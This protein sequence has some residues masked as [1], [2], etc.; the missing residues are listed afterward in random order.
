MPLYPLT[1]KWVSTVSVLQ[2]AASSTKFQPG[3]GSSK[4]GLEGPSLGP[5]PEILDPEPEILAQEPP[6]LATEPQILAPEPPILAPDPPILALEPQILD[7]EPQI[8]A[9]DSP[10]LALGPHIWAR[11]GGRMDGWMYRQMDGR[12]RKF[13]K[14][15]C[16]GHRPLWGRCSKKGNYERKGVG[17]P[18]TPSFTFFL[19]WGTNWGSGPG[20]D[21]DYAFTY[22]EFSPL[23]IHPSIRPSFHLS[24]FDF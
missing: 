1:K 2:T 19:I 14:C 8:L 9:L 23:S 12:R 22:E 15:E 5:E 16:I 13:S 20:R 10:I 18:I 7:L 21:D 4:L 11:G 24:I 17:V 6:I 3:L